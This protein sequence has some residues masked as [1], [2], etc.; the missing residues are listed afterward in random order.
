MS[1]QGEPIGHWTLR[2]SVR[3]RSH[4]VTDTVRR[5][6]ALLLPHWFVRQKLNHASSVLFNYVTLYT[7]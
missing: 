4:V 3:A 7:P 6:N 1:E 5:Y 2:T